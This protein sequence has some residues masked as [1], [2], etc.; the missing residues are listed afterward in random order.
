[1]PL[2]AQ[3]LSDGE[4][5]AALL[6]GGRGSRSWLKL[7]RALLAEWG[8]LAALP[9]VSDTMLR[10]SGLTKTQVSAL[11]AARE[12]AC[13]LAHGK[14]PEYLPFTQPAE[15]ARY[16]ALR[17][18]ERDQEVMGALFLNRRHR[19]IGER[20]L[21]RGTLDRTTVEPRAI[22]RETLARGAAAVCLWHTHPGGDP[23]PSDEDIAF[24]HRMFHAG[25]V[26]GVELVDHLVVGQSGAWVSI[27][28]K[29]GL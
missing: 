29:M 14:V 15:V 4:L 20:E 22:L 6:S 9:A 12:L 2:R 5:V 16:L 26:V 25:A 19:L 11:L 1:V 10:Y 27:R 17:Y 21:F 8:G 18:L 23:T 28:R 3:A 13:R 24:T 7:A